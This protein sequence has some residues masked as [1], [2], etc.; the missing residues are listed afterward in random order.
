MTLNY[1]PEKWMLV[2][3]EL[4]YLSLMTIRYQKPKDLVDRYIRLWFNTNELA[5]YLKDLGK[6]YDKSRIKNDFSTNKE[7]VLMTCKYYR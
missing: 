5:K 1:E 4:Y 7:I 2:N 6:N 3:N